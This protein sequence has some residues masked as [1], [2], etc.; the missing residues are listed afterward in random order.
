MVPD[1]LAS[2]SL[3][4]RALPNFAQVELKQIS[5]GAN[6]EIMAGE[7]ISNLFIYLLN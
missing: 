5:G 6:P 3:H 2:G 4:I 1:C 7:H